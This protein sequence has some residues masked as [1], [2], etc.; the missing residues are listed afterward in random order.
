MKRNPEMSLR[1]GDSTALIRLDAVNPE[2]LNNYYDSLRSIFDEFSFDD[3]L[4]AI[5]NMD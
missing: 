5:Y 4:E 3:H 1:F 2:N